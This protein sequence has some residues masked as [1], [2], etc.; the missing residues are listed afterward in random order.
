M[1]VRV[2]EPHQL[3]PCRTAFARSRNGAIGN[4]GAIRAAITA[5]RAQLRWTTERR[6]GAS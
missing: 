1:T 4:S 6:L 3:V 2:G 5:V